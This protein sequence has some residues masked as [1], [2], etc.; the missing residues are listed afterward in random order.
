[1]QAYAA[2]KAGDGGGPG[3]TAIR[4]RIERFVFEEGRVEV[5]A[6]A[7]GLGKRTIELPEIRLGDVGGANGAPPNEIAKIILATVAGKVASGIADSELDR[8]I[9]EKLGGS[10]TGK[11]KGLLEKIGK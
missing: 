11:A 6:S 1:V 9:N 8:L 4:I 2:G 5:D 7:L 10:I 3:E